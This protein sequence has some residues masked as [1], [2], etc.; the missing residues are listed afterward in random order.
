MNS[1][2]YAGRL[3]R[4]KFMDGREPLLGD[5]SEGQLTAQGA[6]ELR[7]L[8]ADFANA[9]ISTGFL[10]TTLDPSQV[11]VRSTNIDRTF[12]SAINLMLGL[13]PV[14]DAVC[15][16]ADV[17]NI[18]TLD[19]LTENMYPPSTGQCPKLDAIIAA[20]FQQPDW[21]QRINAMKPTAQYLESLWKLPPG[22]ITDWTAFL[23]LFEARLYAG[24]PPLVGITQTIIDS[25]LNTSS[26]ELHAM[27]DSLEAQRLGIGRFIGEILTNIKNKISGSIT[28]KF[29]L[30][31][32]HDTT[33]GPVLSA[34]QAFAPF[35]W[36]PYASH[37]VI[38][39]LSDSSSNYFVTVT[40]NSQ[41]LILPGCG[42][43]ICTLD[44]FT[45]LLQP[46]IPDDWNTECNQ[47]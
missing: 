39:L 27:G 5:C 40:Y 33:V 15:T 41:K 35:G 28:Q 9:Y 2:E 32:G 26:Y 4:K 47:Q 38:E 43:F 34:F 16:L 19:E 37:I 36:P 20:R 1:K 23:D 25:V 17:L 18:Y 11:Y 30:L 29:Y 21:Q 10:S 8:G 24:A 12:E 3:Y 45:K 7:V 6:E 31:S 46:V 22:S 42:Q 14:T 13:Y 44:N